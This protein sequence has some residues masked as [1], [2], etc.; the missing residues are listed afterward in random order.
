MN[1]IGTFFDRVS[2][3]P[4]SGCWNWQRHKNSKGYGVVCFRGKTA[5]AHRVS[6]T[7]FSGFDFDSPL[8]ILHRCD[9]PS[10][11]NPK[12]LFAGGNVENQRDSVLK[13]RHHSVRVASCPNGHPYSGDNLY[14]HPTTKA[15]ACRECHKVWNREISEKRKAARHAR[16][17]LVV[18]KS[19]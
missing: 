4:I 19:R 1:H 13:G 8:H 12:H 3:D 14:I 15:R 16:G 5:S 11:V 18:R 10:C 6:A 17:L 7:L 9:N 2:Q